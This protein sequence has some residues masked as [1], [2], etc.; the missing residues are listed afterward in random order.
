MNDILRQRGSL[1]RYVVFLRNLYPA[2]ETLEDALRETATV[3][4]IA[5]RQVF[6]AP[7]LRA[8][9]TALH[10]A[11]WERDVPLLPAGVD[12]AARIASCRELEGGIGLAGH[13]YTRYLG[14]LNGGQI[15]ARLLSKSLGVPERALNFYAFPGA[16]E[17][18]ALAVSYRAELDALGARLADVSAIAEEAKASFRHSIALSLAVAAI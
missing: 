7:A 15:L 6:R 1:A 4:G 5:C 13:A 17:P 3:E 11:D 18:R 2:Y 14:D 9:L 16:L 10:G 12:Y 8:D